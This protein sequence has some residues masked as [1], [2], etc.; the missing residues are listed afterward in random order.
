MLIS[1]PY[2]GK[3]TF[4]L[5]LLI[6]RLENRLPTAVQFDADYYIIFD[7]QGAKVN[8]LPDPDPDPRLEEC[9]ALADSN[10]YVLQPCSAF[11]AVAERVILAS[12]PKP[13]R[14]RE[15]IKQAMGRCI[16][17]DLP[18]VPELAAIV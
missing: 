17:S 18:S 9:W 12:S 4:L 13:E 2:L 15:W 10:N 6:H 7:E 5:Y 11:Q 1:F 16:I 14:W 3:S 8:P